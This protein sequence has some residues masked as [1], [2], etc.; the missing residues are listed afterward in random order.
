MI[1]KIGP[2]VQG[3]EGRGKTLSLHLAGGVLGGALA[4]T[5]L[6]FVGVI[7]NT[8]V[9]P[10]AETILFV[11][12]SVV[13][14]GAGMVDLEVGRLPAFTSDRQTPGSWACSLGPR[15]AAFAWG[16]DLGTAVRTRFPYQALI[17]IFGYAVLVG[18]FW[19]SVAV[20]TLYGTA[21]AGTVVV[22][23]LVGGSPAEACDALDR[24]HGLLRSVVGSAALMVG[25]LFLGVQMLH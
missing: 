5:L 7:L 19:S 14:I 6:A 12:L 1:G 3:G 25:V 17:P 10:S 18:E 4:G 11:G 21:K 15:S 24:R 22:S 8:L 9:P 16:L 2:L 23:V 13:L 20:M